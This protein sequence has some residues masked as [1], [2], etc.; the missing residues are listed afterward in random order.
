MRP[1]D[2]RPGLGRAGSLAAGVLLT[3]TACSS[4]TE[5]TPPAPPAPPTPTAAPGTTRFQVAGVDAVLRVPEQANGRLVVY[6][7]GAGGTA[8]SILGTEPRARLVEGLVD[9]GYAVVASDAHGDAWGNAESV[10]AHAAAA[11]EA[12]ART[13]TTS[14]FLL[15]ESMGG[16]PGAQLTTGSE[17]DE[18]EALAG[19]YPVCD[20]SSVY[21]R[22]ADS[23]DAAHGDDVDAALDRLSPVDPAGSVPVMVWASPQDTVVPK[24]A[25]GDACVRQAREAGA[26][27][28]V[29]ESTGEHGDP[30]HF[31]L[32]TVLAFFHSSAGEG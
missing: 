1:G 12:A 22:F 4:G 20:L 6:L 30:S 25:N 29:V 21:P 13:G 24:A 7:H 23:V 15:A 19:I 11:E 26:D 14:V 16:L 17:L 18:V 3:L 5:A 31:D 32:P 28:I 9:E 8:E 27:A 10:A 2:R